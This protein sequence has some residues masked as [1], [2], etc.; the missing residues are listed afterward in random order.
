MTGGIVIGKTN[1][2]KWR[3]KIVKELTTAAADRTFYRFLNLPAE[4]R[5]RVYDFHVQD[6]TGETLVHAQFPSIARASELLET[7]SAPVFFSKTTHAFQVVKR[8][9]EPLRLYAAAQ[10][11]LDRLEEEHTGDMRH[12][13]I[14]ILRR[15]RP[16]YLFRSSLD[17]WDMWCSVQV[18]FDPQVTAHT[19]STDHV[20]G[21]ANAQAERILRSIIDKVTVR[22]GM[23]KLKRKDFDDM[24]DAFRAAM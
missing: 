7:E 1:K 19:I 23:R 11:S 17:M 13:E 22:E 9:D 3:S 18:D 10:S 2:R 12:L 6:F 5:S 14:Q 4:L 15:C 16:G 8:P 20:E 24:A 21:K